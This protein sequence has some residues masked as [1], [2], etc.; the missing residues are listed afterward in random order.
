MAARRKTRKSHGLHKAV[1]RGYTVVKRSPMFDDVDILIGGKY[2]FSASDYT[3]AF[4]A[5]DID[6]ER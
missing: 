4:K 5:I 1:Y 6:K 2:Q 3:D